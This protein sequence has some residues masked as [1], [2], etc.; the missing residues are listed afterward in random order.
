MLIGWALDLTY[1]SVPVRRPRPCNVE[2]NAGIRTPAGQG[3]ASPGS[4]NAAGLCA[5]ASPFVVPHQQLEH[6]SPASETAGSDFHPQHAAPD[7]TV[8]EVMASEGAAAASVGAGAAAPP[9]GPG[10]GAVDEALLEGTAKAADDI[11]IVARR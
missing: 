1:R 11:A 9:T 6:P 10:T 4:D 2:E 7:A 3:P 5:A 8:D